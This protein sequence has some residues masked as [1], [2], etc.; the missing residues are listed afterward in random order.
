M[1]EGQAIEVTWPVLPQ[2]D[3]YA[4]LGA[5]VSQFARAPAPRRSSALT[6]AVG[7]ATAQAGGFEYLDHTADVQIHAWGPNMK[8]TFGAAA[9]G[10]FG[11]MVEIEEF[12]FDLAR[13]VTA[14]GHDW[15]SMFFAFLDECLYVFHT[16]A[17]VMSRVVVDSIDT[18]TWT[19][20]ASVRGGLFDAT[21][22]KQGTE[23]KAITYSNMQII[24]PHSESMRELPLDRRAQVYVIVDI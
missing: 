22:D 23:V 5:D 4:K 8:V 15:E 1:A 3:S 14:K 18:E 20:T 24:Q 17:L 19:V 12:G 16:E 7:E 2:R 9:V 10:M 6:N 21:R 11:Y 13:T